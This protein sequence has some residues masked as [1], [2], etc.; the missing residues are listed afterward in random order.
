[1]EAINKIEAL[2]EEAY[3]LAE[4]RFHLLRLKT[5]DKAAAFASSGVW[6]ISLFLLA[7]LF[8]LMIN[9]GL[10]LWVGEKLGK[11]YYGFFIVS[12]FYVLV[13]IILAIFKKQLIK[14]PTANFI[15]K[16]FLHA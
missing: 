12:L 5:V 4:A 16:S 15:I 9:I 11:A 8:V 7:L 3:D 14:T 13:A 6:S 2:G 10:A 1:M